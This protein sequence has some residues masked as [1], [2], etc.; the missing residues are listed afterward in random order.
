ML[1]NLVICL[2]FQQI[3]S[4]NFSSVFKVLKRIDGS[5]Y[6]VKHG[7]KQLHQDAERLLLLYFSIRLPLCY[8]C[9]WN[10]ICTLQEE[11]FD[12]SS[13]F[14][15]FRFVIQLLEYIF[16]TLCSLHA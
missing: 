8:V 1:S 12:G 4:G 13:M 16:I 9:F 7:T 2:I 5:L 15:S 14:G 3:G 11:S 10:N 6:A